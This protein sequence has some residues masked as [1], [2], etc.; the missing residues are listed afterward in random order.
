MPDSVL[1]V[2]TRPGADVW[3]AEDGRVRGEDVAA[4]ADALGGEALSPLSG[5]PAQRL[6]ARRA[7]ERARADMA[8]YFGVR[9]RDRDGDGLL[10]R[11][12]EAPAVEF[13]YVKPPVALPVVP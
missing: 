10:E 13:A 8:H 11:L 4:I 3:A 2:R 1:V 12:R 9:L 6:R 7:G 5:E